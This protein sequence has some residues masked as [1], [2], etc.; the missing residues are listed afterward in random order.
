MQESSKSMQIKAVKAG[1]FVGWPML[2]KWNINKYYPDMDE[3][4]KGQLNQM[5]K[6]MW[7][8]KPKAMPFEDPKATQ[9]KGGKFKM[10]S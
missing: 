6:N 5:C 7:S 9:L 2:T 3:M 4:P 8:T 10:L 1:N